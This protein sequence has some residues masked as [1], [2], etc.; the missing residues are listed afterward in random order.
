MPDLKI[1]QLPLISSVLPTDILPIVDDPSGTPITSKTTVSKL[2]ELVW[3]VGSV[4]LSVVETNPATLFGFGT[5]VSIG[6]G[7]VLVGQNTSD[8]DFDVLEKT[9]GE[10]THVLTESEIPAHTHTQDVHSHTI[11]DA[12]HSHL[13]Q[14][15]PTAT[16]GS[17]GFTN[18]TS[19]SGTLADN[20]LST[21]SATTGITVNN[22][23]ATNQN[24]GGGLAHNNLQPFLVVKMWKRTV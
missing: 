8:V 20:T 21:K 11:N 19:M 4:F 14:R 2:I 23:T 18:D 3:P 13:T 22:A 10:K 7:R 9:G 1:S 24:T 5:W 12:G 15:Y 16:G 17:S 6:D